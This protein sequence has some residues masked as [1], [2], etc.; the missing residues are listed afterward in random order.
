MKHSDISLQTKRTLAN[1]LKN[2]MESKPLSKI[3][4][5]ELC[6]S[7][8]VNR[9]TFYYHFEDM[10][11][12]LKWMLDQETMD[13]V[14]R[15]DLITDYEKIIDFVIEY[16]D[17]N[18]QILNCIYD[19]MSREGMKDFFFTD[20]RQAIGRLICHLS[21]KK[22]LTLSPGFTR[23]ICDFYGNALAGL[24]VDWFRDKSS[25]T[26]KEMTQYIVMILRTSFPAVLEA[27]SFPS[28][29]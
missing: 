15:F 2:L 21:E 29:Q 22:E 19:A 25:Y 18:Q 3:T 6:G 10:H 11:G 14:K 7:C 28:Q 4:V 5:S 20:F 23:F 27:Y 17:D 13:I 1:S 12:L 9:K 24:L 16:V 8:K 26:K